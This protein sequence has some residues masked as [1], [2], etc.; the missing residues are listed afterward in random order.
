MEM[1][2]FVHPT[3]FRPKYKAGLSMMRHCKLFRSRPRAACCLPAA[4]RLKCQLWL[5]VVGALPLPCQSGWLVYS[6]LKLGGEKA[7]CP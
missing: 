6:V 4:V 7:V 5:D 3:R 1:A 2:R